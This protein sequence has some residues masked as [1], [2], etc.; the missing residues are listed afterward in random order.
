MSVFPIEFFCYKQRLIPPSY[1]RH[2]FPIREAIQL[3][4]LYVIRNKQDKGTL[5]IIALYTFV[6]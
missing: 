4:C 1:N 3:H 6:F 2:V 5:H